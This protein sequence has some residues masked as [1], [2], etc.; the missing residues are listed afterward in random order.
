MI[1]VPHSRSSV[2]HGA[3]R[4]QR[5]EHLP[6]CPRDRAHAA[7]DAGEPAD[8]LPMPAGPTSHNPNPAPHRG[9][10][11]GVAPPERNNKAT[12]RAH[13]ACEQSHPESRTT[14]KRAEPRKSEPSPAGQ[15]PASGG[16]GGSPP[17]RN[18]EATRRARTACEQS[19]PETSGAEGIRTPDLLN[20][21]EAR[22]RTALRPLV[23]EPRLAGD[24]GCSLR[25][26]QS[27]AARW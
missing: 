14:Q 23:P 20:A 12:R 1:Q 19:H 4:E 22:Y 26:A 7:V 10:D 15:S 2:S 27:P 13:T 21:T 6:R 8:S 9:G 17:E 11:R 24:A 18:N 25:V 3:I 16:I 5:T